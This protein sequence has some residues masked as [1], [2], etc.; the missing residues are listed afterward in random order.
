MVEYLPRLED[1]VNNDVELQENKEKRIKYPEM[2]K[3]CPVCC[4]KMERRGWKFGR[5][6]KH[7]PYYFKAWDYCNNCRRIQHYEEFKTYN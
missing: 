3:V 7:K 5:E 2:G 6:P 4:K 1:L